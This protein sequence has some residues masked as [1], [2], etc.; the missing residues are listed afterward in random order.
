MKQVMGL[1]LCECHCCAG[2]TTGYNNMLTPHITH[3]SVSWLNAVYDARAL[4]V[5]I[6][7]RAL[8]VLIHTRVLAVLRHTR[9]C[10]GA[11]MRVRLG[12]AH[13]CAFT[14]SCRHT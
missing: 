4:A 2:R 8:A 11:C 10:A 5:L 1:V 9:V 3:P 12:Y 6:H 13:T 14:C 7:T